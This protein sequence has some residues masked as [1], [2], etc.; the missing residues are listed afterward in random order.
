MSS[1]SMDRMAKA[2]T[3]CCDGAVELHLGDQLLLPL[4]LAGGNSTF[5]TPRLAKHLMTN[6]WNIVQFAIADISIGEGTP[7][8]VNIQPRHWR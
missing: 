3:R 7:C 2:V 5:T 1:P 8:R 4:S 6:A